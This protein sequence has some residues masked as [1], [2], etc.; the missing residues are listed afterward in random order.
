MIT[1]EL[2][3][4][5]YLLLT[6]VRFNGQAPRINSQIEKHDK[7]PL[8]DWVHLVPEIFYDEMNGYDFDLL[9]AGTSPDFE[10]VRLAFQ[11]AGISEDEVRLIHKNEL[12]DADT[13]SQE[14]DALLAWLRENPKRK[15]DLSAF[16]EEQLELFEGSYTY[17]VIGGPAPAKSE[18]YI[19]IETINSVKE[20]ASTVLTSTPILFY[21]T[22]ENMSQFRKDLSMLLLRK[23]VSQKQL[24]FMIHPIMNNRQVTRVIED[25]GVKTPQVVSSYFDEIIKKYIRNYP[26]TEYIRT[27]I[28]VFE[29]TVDSISA[30]LAAEIEERIAINADTHARIDALELDI[31]RLKETD[32]FFVQ[33]DNYAAPRTIESARQ[34]LIEQIQRWRNRKTKIVGDAE[35]DIAAVEYDTYLAK[36]FQNCIAKISA[37]R[38]S[39]LNAIESDFHI[40][41]EN[42]QIDTAY[43]PQDIMP[44]VISS[45][46]Y[47]SLHSDFMELKEVT[48]EEAK[49][50]FFGLFRKS[51]ETDA[52]PVQVVTSYLEQWRSQA[53]ERLLPIVDEFIDEVTASLVHHYYLLAEAYHGKLTELLVTWSDEKEQVSSTLSD[54]EKKLQQDNDWLATFRDQLYKIER[55]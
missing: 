44:R 1:A 32:N 53:E 55:G 25:L 27:A 13:K 26:V 52:E 21:I 18:S 23:D 8:K 29:E 42:G 5:P 22:N 43:Q 33:R 39:A 49:G 30:V 46:I 28:S 35:A 37:E 50:D 47:P 15:F 36:A 31:A 10:E 19:G 4:N 11:Q 16:L 9:F 24:F 51:P 40:I 34:E 54:D 41:Y 7:Q 38:I 17:I 12:E 48:Y 2:S 6:S 14:I 3:H 20:L 45:P